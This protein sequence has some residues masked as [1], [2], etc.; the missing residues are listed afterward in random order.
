MKPLPLY[1]EVDTYDDLLELANEYDV[2]VHSG[3]YEGVRGSMQ[4]LAFFV[5]GTDDNRKIHWILIGDVLRSVNA[6]M[7]KLDK[8][9]EQIELLLD[10]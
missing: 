7:Q 4:N 3:K 6:K 1:Q 5:T 8:R 9:L 10:D 2:R